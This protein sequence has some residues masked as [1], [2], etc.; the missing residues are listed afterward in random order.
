[1]LNRSFDEDAIR[2]ILGGNWMRIARSVWKR[3]Q[4]PTM[5]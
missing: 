3:P 1:L 2:G 4:G 5:A